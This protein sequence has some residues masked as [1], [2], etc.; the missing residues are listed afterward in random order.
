MF[1]LT[2]FIVS[3]QGTVVPTNEDIN[4]VSTSDDNNW[5]QIHFKH[6]HDGLNPHTHFPEKHDKNTKRGYK[7]TDA[8]DLDYADKMLREGKMRHR[9][10]RNDRGGCV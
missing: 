8:N 7:A 9:K 10:N 6:E 4:L 5:F 1:G 2:D 3:P